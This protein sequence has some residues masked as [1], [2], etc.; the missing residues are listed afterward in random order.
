[1]TLFVPIFRRVPL[2][3]T[4]QPSGPLPGYRSGR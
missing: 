4:L 3:G 1:V 2:P